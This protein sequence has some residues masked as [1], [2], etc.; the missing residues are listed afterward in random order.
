MDD[1]IG[2]LVAEIGDDRS[3]AV[4]AA[5]VVVRCLR[6][7]RL[8]EAAHALANQY[9]A[10][11]LGSGLTLSDSSGRRMGTCAAGELVGATVPRL[12]I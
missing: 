5:G 9:P 8:A 10:S 4:M 7:E 2:R 3:A 1:R 6:A 11:G 12:H